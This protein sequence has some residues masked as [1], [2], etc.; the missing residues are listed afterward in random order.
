MADLETNYLAIRTRYNTDREVVKM[1]WN[2]MD[3]KEQDII[4]LLDYIEQLTVCRDHWK[5]SYESL[6]KGIE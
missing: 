5:M 4:L 3:D 2:N 1:L 6:K